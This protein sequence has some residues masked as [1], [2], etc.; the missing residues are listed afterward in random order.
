MKINNKDNDFMNI[1]SKYEE[2]FCFI[3]TLTRFCLIE[4]INSS[5]IYW[6]KEGIIIVNV[7]LFELCLTG[8]EIFWLSCFLHESVWNYLRYANTVVWFCWIHSPSIALSLR[9]ILKSIKW[10]ISCLPYTYK[11]LIVN[12]CCLSNQFPKTVQSCVLIISFATNC[13][14]MIKESNSR[15][16]CEFL[17]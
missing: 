2:V 7:F 1:L 3:F 8:K 6:S 12:C 11:S 16:I 15:W 14:P 5:M 4:E 13:K 17:N 9:M 10:I